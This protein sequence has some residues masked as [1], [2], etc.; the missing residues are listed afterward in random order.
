MDIRDVLN[1]L[2]SE[3]RQAEEDRI[4]A[5]NEAA[6]QLTGAEIE[7][8]FTVEESSGNAGGIDLK[9]IDASK[10]KNINASS[11]QKITLS[12]TALTDSSE[13]SPKPLGTRYLKK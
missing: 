13:G 3:L 7:F 2:T 12:L 11:I 4:A 1:K 6:L 10:T 5:G 9:V 8:Q